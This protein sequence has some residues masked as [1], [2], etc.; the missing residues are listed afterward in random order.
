MTKNM[1]IALLGEGKNDY[2]IQG[3]NTW[4]EGSIQ[5][6]LRRFEQL[7][8]AKIIPIIKKSRKTVAHG[9]K[10]KKTS[11]LQLRLRL[12]LSEIN[13]I[14]LIIVFKDCDKTSGRSPSKIEAKRKFRI[15]YEE[16]KNEL[17]NIENDF[18]IKGVP[19]IPIRM[20]ENWLLGDTM[21][22]NEIWG[23]IPNNP[24]L[25][26][27]PEF[28][29][30]DE[31]DR[32]SNHP[33]NYITKVLNQYDEDYCTENFIKIAESTNI[34]TLCTTCPNSFKLFYTD[35]SEVLNR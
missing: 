21:S 31:Q 25:P 6:L 27:E 30:G 4:K 23:N 11:P 8:D 5:P 14:N 28:V 9:R 29:W 1:I 15:V 26:N 34:E 19:M 33:K 17:E 13:D 18:N 16:L 22:Y 3:R 24:R 2:G 35:I 10:F 7:R 32:D 12:F 20:L